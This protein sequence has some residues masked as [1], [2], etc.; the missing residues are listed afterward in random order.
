MKKKTERCSYKKLNQTKKKQETKNNNDI[1]LNE[2]K[3]SVKA[4]STQKTAFHVD[5]SHRY[6]IGTKNP[7]GH[8]RIK[9]EVDEIANKSKYNYNSMRRADKIDKNKQL[10]NLNETKRN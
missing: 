9:T 5:L 3:Q 7:I 2:K 1:T 8:I 4:N 10:F 6:N